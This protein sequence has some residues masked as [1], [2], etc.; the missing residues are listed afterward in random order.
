MLLFH[1]G[2]ARSSQ[3]LRAHLQVRHQLVR[4]PALPAPV[5][6]RPLPVVLRRQR[7]QLAPVPVRQQHYN[8]NNIKP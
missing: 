5:V 4:Q 8:E 7:L 1:S 6:L 3:R 2:D